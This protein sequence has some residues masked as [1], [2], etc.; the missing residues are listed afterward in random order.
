MPGARRGKEGAEDPRYA[1][2]MANLR[3][4]PLDFRGFDSSTILILRGGI[5]RSI[6][7]FPES[8]SQAILAGRL[9]VGGLGVRPAPSPRARPP[10]RGRR[11]AAPRSAGRPRGGGAVTAGFA[12]AQG[13][14]ISG[15][16][17]ST[18]NVQNPSPIF[19]L[20]VK[21]PHLQFLGQSTIIF[22]PHILKHPIPE[23]PGGAL[24][25]GGGS[26]E[27]RQPRGPGGHP[28]LWRVYVWMGVRRVL[29][30]RAKAH[31]S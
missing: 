31:G 5:L 1:Q 3:T 22:K 13:Y 29:V 20:G 25:L 4:K 14:G 8:F 30:R 24:G 26:G 7:N 16:G 12:R 18:Y 19:A 21:S 9:L 2:R 11:S 6:G 28:E 23:L 10:H 27:L 17:V 15:C